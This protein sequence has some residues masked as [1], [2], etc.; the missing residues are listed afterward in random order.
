V[1]V[2]VGTPRVRRR[3]ADTGLVIDVRDFGVVL[4]YTPDEAT[5][6]AQA[7]LDAVRGPR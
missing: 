1:S 2:R 6:L 3:W 5:S 4:T 7:L